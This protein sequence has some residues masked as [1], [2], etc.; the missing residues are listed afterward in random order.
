VI[1][2]GHALYVKLECAFLTDSATHSATTNRIVLGSA[3]IA[4]TI[5]V[6]LLVVTTALM[7][8]IAPIMVQTVLFVLTV[9]AKKAAVVLSAYMIPTA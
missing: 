4:S 1:K 3:Q 7:V 6:Y 5:N 2:A 8:L 9:D